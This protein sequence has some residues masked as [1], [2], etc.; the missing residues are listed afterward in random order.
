MQQAAAFILLILSLLLGAGPAAARNYPQLFN[1]SEIVSKSFALKK[2]PVYNWT[3]MLQ[4]WKNGAPCET[5]VC[6]SKSWAGLVAQVKAAGDP[7]AQVRAANQLIN[8]HRYIEDMPNWN[9]SDYWATAF[10]FLKKNGDCEDFSI[11]KYMLLKAA[12]YPVENM[13]VFAVRLR[14]LGGIGHAI[15]IVY[16][17]NKAWVLD[18]RNPSVMDANLVALEFQPV[19]SMNEQAWWVH[20]PNH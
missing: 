1:S 7:M 2:G 13:R 18:N 16:Q 6:S 19:L 17:G 10:E 20:V 3:G 5:P 8:A 9:R 4:N 15:L 12:G 14:N 11:T